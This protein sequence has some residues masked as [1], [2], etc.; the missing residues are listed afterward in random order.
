MHMTI[1]ATQSFNRRLR[2][3]LLKHETVDNRINAEY[4]TI[5][6]TF[7]THCRPNDQTSFHN[8]T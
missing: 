6:S 1:V 4:T 8:N 5:K 3:N 2:T 7:W